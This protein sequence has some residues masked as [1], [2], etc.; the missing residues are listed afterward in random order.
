ML[1]KSD[2]AYI[3]QT[4]DKLIKAY[5]IQIPILDIDSLIKT[6]GGKIIERKNFAM[7]TLSKKND[8]NFVIAI[9]PDNNLIRRKIDLIRE[10]GY[11][12]LC[13]GFRMNSSTWESV[14]LN[15]FY[16][17][18]DLNK[19][20]MTDY[21]TRCFLM[22]KKEFKDIFQE[23]HGCIDDIANYFQVSRFVVINRAKDLR[24]KY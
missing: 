1:H 19:Y 4:V 24:L 12:F 7:G 14:S 15:R 20:T 23:Y 13:L 18:N 10:L 3:E 17:F 6:F 21:F 22:P 11:L 8:N 2:I 5:D 16:S 9:F